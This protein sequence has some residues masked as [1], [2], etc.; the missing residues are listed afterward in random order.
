MK[1]D[2]GAPF[3]FFLKD[4]AWF[5]KVALAS[6][7]TY[8]LIGITPVLGWTLQITRQVARNGEAVLPEW[9]GL[10]QYWKEGLKYW[11]LNLIWVFPILLAIL[12][13]DLPIFFMRSMG[14]SQ[15]AIVELGTMA[16][17]LA[18]MVAYLMPVL[19]L[20]PAALAT[21]ACTGSLRQAINPARA[22]RQ[23]RAHLSAHLLV[24]AIIGIG[25]STILSIVGLLTLFIA[26]P[27]LLVYAWLV[28]AHFSGQ[29]Y[30]LEEPVGPDPLPMDPAAST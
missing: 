19:F 7:L 26:L 10:R 3:G 12:S 17:M 6:L 30:R 13:V 1:L 24:F 14:A 22:W 21:L 4:R 9:T 2:Y 15:W 5:K 11:L 8:T 16:C 28:L 20:L 27:P 18:F 23:C 29:L 25:L